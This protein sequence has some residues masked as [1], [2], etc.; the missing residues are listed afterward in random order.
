MILCTESLN[1]IFQ[2]ALRD[3]GAYSY[4]LCWL[5]CPRWM[6]TFPVVT[7][8]L[9]PALELTSGERHARCRLPIRKQMSDFTG[10]NTGYLATRCS[11]N[12]VSRNARPCRARCSAGWLPPGGMLQGAIQPLSS[13]RQPEREARFST[14]RPISVK[15]EQI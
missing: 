7:G 13:Q 15:L 10:V 9:A 3:S 8:E 14:W 2:R 12:K 4:C 1:P 11:V 5:P 6:E